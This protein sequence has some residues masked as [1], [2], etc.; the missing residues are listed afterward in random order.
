MMGEQL[1]QEGCLAFFQAL[2]VASKAT[3]AQHQNKRPLPRFPRRIIVVTSSTGAAIRDFLEVVRRRW[4]GL[5]VLVIP[6]RVQGAGAAQQIARAIV[7]ANRVRPQA[8]VLVVT[9]G[10]GSLARAPGRGEG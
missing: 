10:G 7:A 2:F 6:T 8:D 1:Y 4:R 5:Q 9:R 3:I